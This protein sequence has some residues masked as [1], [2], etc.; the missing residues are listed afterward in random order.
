MSVWYET[1][2][3]KGNN[4]DSAL[5]NRNHWLLIATKAQTKDTQINNFPEE[6]KKHA[7]FKTPSDRESRETAVVEARNFT[8][9]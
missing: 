3:L 2:F 6:P 5:T 4:C 9:L 1:M 8:I 7:A